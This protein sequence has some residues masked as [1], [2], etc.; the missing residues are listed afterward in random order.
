MALKGSDGRVVC[1]GDSCE[2]GLLRE[3]TVA[4]ALAATH[5]AFAALTAQGAVVTWGAVEH[6]G[7]SVQVQQQLVDVVQLAATARAFCA[8]R[9]DGQAP[10][11]RNYNE[12]HVS[13]ES[14]L[15]LWYVSQRRACV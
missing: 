4:T 5:R 10:H 15:A 3:R 1:W 2:G 14:V 6:G 7:G 11:M 13:T 12:L 9:R 8:V